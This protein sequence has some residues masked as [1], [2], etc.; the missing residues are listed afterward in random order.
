[1]D[2]EIKK[3][4]NGTESGVIASGAQGSIMVVLPT[5]KATAFEQKI[6]RYNEFKSFCFDMEDAINKGKFK[7]TYWSRGLMDWKLWT[8]ES[9]PDFLKPAEEVIDLKM[10]AKKKDT[11][12]VPWKK[13][14]PANIIE[15]RKR[16]D[17]DNQDRRTLGNDFSKIYPDKNPNSDA[18]LPYPDYINDAYAK[19]KVKWFTDH[20]D[21][22]PAPWQKDIAVWRVVK[23]PAFGA[24]AAKIARQKELAKLGKGPEPS[25][26]NYFYKLSFT[27]E[28]AKKALLRNGGS[29]LLNREIDGDDDEVKERKAKIFNDTEMDNNTKLMGM[30]PKTRDAILKSVGYSDEQIDKIVKGSYIGKNKDDTGKSIHSDTGMTIKDYLKAKESTQIKS[31][32]DILEENTIISFQ[33]MLK[34]NL[35]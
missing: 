20:P 28:A 8:T 27:K 17:A 11:R 1:M 26:G 7:K 33:D 10:P 34:Q 18:F 23:R 30:D 35:C 32:Q 25:T 2:V 14:V 13:L 15:D 29:F 5:E 16:M 24:W 21:W 4:K 31:F 22:E 19:A 9:Y 12:E 3:L 6:K